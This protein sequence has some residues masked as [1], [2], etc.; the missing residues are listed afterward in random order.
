MESICKRCISDTAIICAIC[1]DGLE[2]SDTKVVLTGTFN[3]SK[4]NYQWQQKKPKKEKSALGKAWQT[5]LEAG[6]KNH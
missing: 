3:N 1:V 2:E 6:K 4:P 5:L